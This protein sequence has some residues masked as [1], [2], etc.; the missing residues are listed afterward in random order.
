MNL[1]LFPMFVDWLLKRSSL[2]GAVSE[3][4]APSVTP[5][6]KAAEADAVA[7]APS[8]SPPLGSL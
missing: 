7:I 5:L 1:C 4:P 2:R 3:V 6:M 8:T